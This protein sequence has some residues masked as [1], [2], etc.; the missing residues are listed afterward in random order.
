M[1]V[2]PLHLHVQKLLFVGFGRNISEAFSAAKTLHDLATLTCDTISNFTRLTPPANLRSLRLIMLDLLMLSLCVR[3]T[4]MTWI[5]NNI[6]STSWPILSLFDA[7]LR[8][9]WQ[10][11]MSKPNLIVFID[12]D[13]WFFDPLDTCLSSFTW[14]TPPPHPTTIPFQVMNDGLCHG[15]CD[16]ASETTIFGIADPNLPNHCTCTISIKLQW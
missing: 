9:L 2:L 15:I 13:L 12:S 8:K 5:R 4:H 11:K 1:T 10:W 14:N 3:H 7:I 6:S 16:C